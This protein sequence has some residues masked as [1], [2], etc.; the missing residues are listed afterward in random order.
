[1]LW[2]IAVAGKL[3]ALWMWHLFQMYAPSLSFSNQCDILVR[4][5][6][7]PTCVNQLPITVTN[8]WDKSTYKE[9]K[10]ILAHSVSGSSPW[11]FGPVAFSPYDALHGESE[12]WSK[13]S[14]FMARNWK[15]RK[16]KRLRSHDL[17][18]C[19]ASDDPK[20]SHEVLPLNVPSPFIA[21]SWRIGF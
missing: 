15:E 16:R 17:L 19:Y 7:S 5:L 20:I 18:Q 3:T 6:T 12:W 2:V 10:F 4:W 13:I 14:Y 8:T 9:R 1:M 21:P 11:L